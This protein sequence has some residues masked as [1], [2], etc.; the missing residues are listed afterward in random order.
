[1]FINKKLALAA[2]LAPALAIGSVY[3]A[4]PGF[5][6]GA[7]GGQSFIDDETDNIQWDDDETG[8]KAYLGYQFLPWLGVEAG[9]VDFG[10]YSG[11]N[12][13]VGGGNLNTDAELD[14]SAWQGFLVGSLPIG[15]VD[16]FAKVGAA[17]LQA[18]IDN[19]RFGT[20]QDNDTQLAY[21]VGAAYNFGKGHWGL[22]V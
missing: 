8:W 10:Q 19:A 13:Q 16:L 17:D 15:P 3:A 20:E 12:V 7:S 18:E 21:G 2:L 11:D 9:Y 22:R 4:E 14:L 6:L 5:Y 1:M